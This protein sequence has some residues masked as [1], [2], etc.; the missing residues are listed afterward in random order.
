[1]VVTRMDTPNQDWTAYDFYNI[2]LTSNDKR[3]LKNQRLR[4]LFN[5]NNN[6]NASLLSILPS[7]IVKEGGVY[8]RILFYLD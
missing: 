3:S 1:M 7:V 2:N 5:S 8:F 4:Q 6:G